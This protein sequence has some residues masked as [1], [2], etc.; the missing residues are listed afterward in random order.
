MERRYDDVRICLSLMVDVKRKEM[1]TAGAQDKYLILPIGEIAAV[2]RHKNQ[3][4]RDTGLR[5]C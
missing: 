3:D 2:A 4:E 1:S 5:Y